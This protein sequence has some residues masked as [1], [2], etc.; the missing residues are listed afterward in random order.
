M[1]KYINRPMNEFWM[2]GRSFIAQWSPRC[3]DYSCDH[4]QGA[5][6]NT[7]INKKS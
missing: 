5:N 1:H 7:D 4:L 3:F 6:K 2:Y